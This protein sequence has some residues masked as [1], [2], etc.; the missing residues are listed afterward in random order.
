[1][2]KNP[3]MPENHRLNAVNYYLVKNEH[4]KISTCTIG[5]FENQ[6]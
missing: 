3:K 2:A 5:W 6:M 1:M 4:E